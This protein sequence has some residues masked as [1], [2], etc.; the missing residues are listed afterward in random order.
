MEEIDHN[1]TLQAAAILTELPVAIDAA[2]G[3][4]RSL[5]I[6]CFPHRKNYAQLFGNLGD[7]RTEAV[8]ALK[9]SCRSLETFHFGK[10]GLA[11]RGVQPD[12]PSHTERA[13]M[14][15]YLRVMVS[16]QRLED[17]YLNFYAFSQTH[18]TG[19][20]RKLR[21]LDGAL[22]FQTRRLRRIN[23]IHASLTFAELEALIRAVD[24]NLETFTLNGAE[25]SSGSWADILDVLR[26]KTAA[27]C[28][29]GR[30][31]LQLWDLY[32]GEFIMSASNDQ[33]PPDA[34]QDRM[35]R[36]HAAERYLCGSL[37]DNPL[38]EGSNKTK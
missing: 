36:I 13:Y 7:K 4:V 9:K 19:E 1:S 29:E 22:S 35:A 28:Q 2:G 27:R 23:V 33:E 38:R 26:V 11:D 10:I 31:A 30:C 14:D 18:G 17:L 8:S 16:S 3:D 34:R 21:P 6:G 5:S 37:P 24:R 20:L 32:G 25:L 12:F 15:D